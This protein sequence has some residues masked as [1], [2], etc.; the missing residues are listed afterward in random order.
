MNS[1]LKGI[2][3]PLITPLANYKELDLP[4]TQRLIEHQIS[5]KV[6]A[7]FILGSTGEGPSLSYALRKELISRVCEW[8]DQRIP[9]LV[10][11]TDTSLEG[12]LE[13]SAHAESAGADAVVI[14]PPYYYPIADEEIVLYLQQLAS[15]LSLPFVLYNMPSHTKLHLSVEIVKQAHELGAIGIKDSSGDMLFLNSLLNAFKES[16]GFSILSGTELFLPE[17]IRY[18]GHGGVTGGANLFPELFASLYLAAVSDDSESILKLRETVSMIYETI[19]RVGKDS[20]RFLQSYK[21]GLSVMGICNDYMA[22]PLQ[23]FGPA[24]RKQMETYMNEFTRLT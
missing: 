10:G 22:P 7:L 8:V 9:V 12:S 5:G 24:E 18:G 14:A 1:P 23:S 3:T 16:P 19:Y 17:T 20:S 15:G 21:C 11:I 2:I 13:I 6:D 4:G